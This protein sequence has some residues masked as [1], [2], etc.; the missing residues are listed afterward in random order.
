MKLHTPGHYRSAEEIKAEPYTSIDTNFENW[1]RN[2][3]NSV[4]PTGRFQFYTAFGVQRMMY[5]S[6]VRLI[7]MKVVYSLAASADVLAASKLEVDISK[8]YE[9]S[10]AQ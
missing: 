8:I 7:I 2:N 1:Q 4:D 10:T 3:D 5:L 9:G 6:G